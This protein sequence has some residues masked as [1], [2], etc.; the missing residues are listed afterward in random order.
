MPPQSLASPNLFPA[1]FPLVNR[2]RFESRQRPV[3][4]LNARAP[5]ERCRPFR[6]WAPIGWSGILPLLIVVYAGRVGTGWT[7]K[8]SKSLRDTIEELHAAKPAFGQPL[9]R[10]ADKD[11][12]WAR[13]TL[14]CEIEL[15]GWTAD[16]LIR[17]GSFK[18]LRED[19]PAREVVREKTN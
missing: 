17:Q 18:G 16:R 3:R 5:T 9:P 15:R 12:R 19:K 6:G 2:D 4:V 10:G 1:G 11:V 7:R 14:V 8:G 13:P